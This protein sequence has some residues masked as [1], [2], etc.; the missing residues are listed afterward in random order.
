MPRRGKL[1]GKERSLE[2]RVEITRL[3]RFVLAIEAARH[4]SLALVMLLIPSV[5]EVSV[6]NAVDDFVPVWVFGI[7]FLLTGLYCVFAVW[8]T[9]VVITRHAFQ[10]S[11]IVTTFWTSAFIAALIFGNLAS[12][13]VII[14]FATLFAIDSAFVASSVT[15]KG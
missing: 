3:S 10:T 8:K 13:R 6:Y 15:K 12:L 4:L 2:G 1:L 5:F 14:P 9:S 7:V 11:A